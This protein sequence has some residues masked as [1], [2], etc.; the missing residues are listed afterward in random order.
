MISGLLRDN[1]GLDG[2][3]CQSDS[4]TSASRCYQQSD[5]WSP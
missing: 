3:V 4:Q 2:I 5:L 1:D